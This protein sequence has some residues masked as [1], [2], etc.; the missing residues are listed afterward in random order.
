MNAYVKD[1]DHG[2]TS[3]EATKFVEGKH[4][5]HEA[6]IGSV[7]FEHSHWSKSGELTS[8][9]SINLFNRS[10]HAEFRFWEVS[11]DDLRSLAAAFLAAADSLDAHIKQGPRLRGGAK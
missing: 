7:S 4:Y 6:N 9:L 3:I 2:V 10:S 5:L 11:P 1:A 8:L